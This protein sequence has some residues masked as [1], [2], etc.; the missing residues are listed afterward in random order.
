MPRACPEHLPERCFK[1]IDEDEFAAQEFRDAVIAELR[2]TT[3]LLQ[4]AAAYDHW[5][6]WPTCSGMTQL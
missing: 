1:N 2:A 5:R 3:N 6:L 4:A